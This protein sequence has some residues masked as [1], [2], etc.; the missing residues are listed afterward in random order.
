[1]RASEGD[2]VMDTREKRKAFYNS[3][4]WID[5]R[6]LQLRA[7]R[8]ASTACNWADSCRQWK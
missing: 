7:S 5:F 3:K 2:A 6:A 8:C 1:M 4:A